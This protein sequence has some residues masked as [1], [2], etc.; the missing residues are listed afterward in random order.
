MNRATVACAVVESRAAV[1]DQSGPAI[2]G[3]VA[4]DFVGRVSGVDED[5]IRVDGEALVKGF[6]ILG[7]EEAFV[8]EKAGGCARGWA[9]VRA[10]RQRI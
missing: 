2:V 7:G 3:A 10:T 8:P 4:V 5:E 1:A 9:N 6:S